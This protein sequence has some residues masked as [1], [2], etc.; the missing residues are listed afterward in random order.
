MQTSLLEAINAEY[1]FAEKNISIEKIALDTMN[2]NFIIHD[3][4]KKYFLKNYRLDVAGNRERLEEIHA[5]EQFF[6]S[7]SIPVIT[8]LRTKNGANIFQHENEF[9]SIYPFVE[10]IT[11][12]TPEKLSDTNITCLGLTLAGIHVAGKD[13]PRLSSW[14]YNGWSTEKFF[15][16]YRLIKESIISKEDKTEFDLLSLELLELKNRFVL[17]LGEKTKTM[18]VNDHLIHGD[19]HERNVFFTE[20]GGIHAVFDF[21]KSALY[22]RSIEL[23]RSLDIVCVFGAIAQSKNLQIAKTYLSAYNSVYKISKEEFITGFKEQIENRISSLNNHSAGKEIIIS[24]S[25]KLQWYVKDLDAIA[26]ELAEVL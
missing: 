16:K 4:H 10:A 5:I 2:P 15:D 7:R 11:I 25:N 26:N 21:E 23:A 1:H 20:K 13:A 6:R 19:F 18:L 22:P 17:S 14:N 12:D 9:Y 3:S 8:P 24:E